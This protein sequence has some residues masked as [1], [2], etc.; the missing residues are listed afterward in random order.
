ML[1]CMHGQ[2]N[3]AGETNTEPAC[4]SAN[5]NKSHSACEMR[6]I[7]IQSQKAV[8]FTKVKT[9]QIWGGKNPDKKSA[10]I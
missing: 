3:G 4:Y 8:V 10:K 2:G 7:I 6:M 5:K 9:G 1:L